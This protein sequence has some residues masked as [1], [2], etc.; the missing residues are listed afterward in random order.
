MLRVIDENLELSD[1]E[2][3][4]CVLEPEL[5]ISC[6]E[7]Q[8]A[9]FSSIDY[10]IDSFLVRVQERYIT[11]PITVR[12]QLQNIFVKQLN[13]THIP[14]DII[15]VIDSF[16]PKA[17]N[18]ENVR[19]VQSRYYLNRA[20]DGNHILRTENAKKE[21]YCLS[22][23]ARDSWMRY[24]HDFAGDLDGQLDE[25]SLAR[26]VINYDEDNCLTYDLQEFCQIHAI[27]IKTNHIG[28]GK[29]T[30]R[31]KI[32]NIC[33]RED[34][35]HEQWTVHSILSVANYN[36]WLGFVGLNILSQLIQIEFDSDGAV[37]NEL[38]FV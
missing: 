30:L 1:D 9:S 26:I 35:A 34:D 21:K 29:Q 32:P 31:V 37:V 18:M 24:D 6:E 14:F 17:P 7:L 11:N 27:L 19:F 13:E 22:A 10:Q 12:H 16:L 28:L 4:V 3:I 25:H 5:L 2:A 8:T 20:I 36:G 15:T 38:L 23:L 33:K